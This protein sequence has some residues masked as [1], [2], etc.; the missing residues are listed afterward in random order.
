MQMTKTEETMSAD[1]ND[2]FSGIVLW[3]AI[4]TVFAIL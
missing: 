2:I 4:V 3:L 1:T